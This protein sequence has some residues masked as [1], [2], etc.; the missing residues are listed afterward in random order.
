[1]R[2]TAQF[3]LFTTLMMLALQMLPINHAIAN[4]LLRGP[5]LQNQSPSEL[6][7]RWRTSQAVNSR[8]WWGKNQGE[9]THQSGADSLT[10]EHSLT[11]T[12]LTPATVYH[13]AIGYDQTLLAGNDPTHFFTTPPM[14]GE[15]SPV[16]FWVL[17]D[18]G[19][20]NN[21]A[22]AVRDA[23][24][25]YSTQ[26]PTHLWF[27]LGDN[28][29]PL[30]TDEEYQSAVFDMYPQ[31]LRQSTLWPTIGN[32]D[33]ANADS[34]TGTGVYYE[35]FTLPHQANSTGHGIGAD[36]GTEAY[37]SFNY[38]NIHFI[39][40]DSDETLPSFRQAQ[41]DWLQSDLMLNQADWTIA[42]WHHPPYTKGSHDSDIESRHLH[43]REHILP[44][45]ESHGVDLVL[46]GHSHSYERSW[47]IDG[48]YGHSNTFD[49]DHIVNDGSGN[50][51]IDTA[52]VK[53]PAGVMSHQGTVYVVAGSS[54][55][56]SSTQGVAHPAMRNIEALRELGSMVVEINGLSLTAQFLRADGQIEDLFTVIKNDALFN[57]SFDD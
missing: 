52:Y 4:D 50:P 43:M 54:G 24:L 17:G 55:K 7:I 1:M 19:T 22:L 46:G 2:P 51:H 18:S 14:H 29:Y 39:I 16:R 44:V 37:Y 34:V 31:I 41:L 9:L 47:L 27:M 23:Y 15:T 5:Y 49:T 6:T 33:A 3:N 48:H 25:Q 36:S 42:M 30:G 26:Q 11:I 32:H 10:T 35:L 21:D 13:Y 28:A 8:L 56:T 45:L 40:L 20:G 12:G 57:N 53:P 38:A